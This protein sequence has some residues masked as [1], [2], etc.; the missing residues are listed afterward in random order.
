[1]DRLPL[2]PVSDHVRAHVPLVEFHTLD[3]VQR[4]LDRLGLLDGDDALPSDGIHCLG[5]QGPNL[6]VVVGGYGGDLLDRLAGLD[7]H[8]S[9][10]QGID[11]GLYSVIEP[12]LQ[13]HWARS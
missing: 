13:L 11:Y 4:G 3:Y 10:L 12:G 1:M 9:V 7:R 2:L 6:L 5:D 8:C